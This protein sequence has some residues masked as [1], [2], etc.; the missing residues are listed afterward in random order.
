MFS[1][2]IHVAVSEPHS[3]LKIIYL[4][5]IALGLCCCAHFLWL[6]QVGLLFTAVASFVVEHRLWVYGLQ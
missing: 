3:F 4:L 1:R 2:L 5:L 6:W